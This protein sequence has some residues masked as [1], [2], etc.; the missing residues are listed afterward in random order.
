MPR[1]AEPGDA[2]AVGSPRRVTAQRR[3]ATLLSAEGTGVDLAVSL[4]CSTLP[5]GE[6]PDS[7]VQREDTALYAARRKGR[8]RLDTAG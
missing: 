7:M 5:P 4:G 6:S 3:T 2:D 1:P 8:H